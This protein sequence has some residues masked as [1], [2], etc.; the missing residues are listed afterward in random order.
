MIAAAIAAVPAH[1]LP[2]LVD[3]AGPVVEQRRRFAAVIPT[4]LPR[5]AE[6]RQVAQ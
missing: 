3:L 6:Q 1:E 5:R 4:R 2:R